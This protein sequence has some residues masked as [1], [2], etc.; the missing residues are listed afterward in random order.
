MDIAGQPRLTAR[1]LKEIATLKRTRGRRDLR[2]TIVEGVRSVH[3]LVISNVE[4]REIIVNHEFDLN[5]HPWL[6]GKGTIHV[7]QQR[8]FD[9][10]SD[11]KTSQGIIAVAPVRKVDIHP[12]EVGR[13][14]VFLDGLGDPGNAG[15]I[16]R[17]AAWFG[18]D[19][20]VGGPGTVDLFSPKV[21]RSSMGGIWDVDIAETPDMAESVREL[22]EAG[23]SI[24]IA[25][26]K[27]EDIA[28]WTPEDS[29]VLVI[30]NEA[31]GVSAAVREVATTTL[32]IPRT[33]RGRVV[34]SLNAAISCGIFLQH[35][36]SRA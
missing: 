32:S 23:Y 29:T 24:C 12:H 11:V 31:R 26:M 1:R 16:L 25:D 21:V 19:L 34:E 4:I 17:S 27:G 8:K 3:S 18:I 28:G 20:V 30:G 2:E 15:A 13:R 14:I 36:C 22:R 35:W 7:I 33:G 10:L 6:T 9:Q 5:A